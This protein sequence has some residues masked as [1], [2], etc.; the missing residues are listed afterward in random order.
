MKEN[1]IINVIDS[2]SSE[3]EFLSNFCKCK[4]FFRGI[5][6]PTLEHAYQASKCSDVRFK[7]I[8]A[9][10][11]SPY[12]AKKMGRSCFDPDWDSKKVE[13][14]YV[15]LKYKFSQD[16][17]KQKLLATEN[18]ELVEGNWWGDTYWG[19]CKGKGENMLGKLLMRVRKELRINE[20]MSKK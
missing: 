4:I 15:L 18:I 17:F 6:Y 8:I 12:Q 14:M 13:I 19:I 10:N 1:Q 16:S 20:K 3:Y 5:K 11:P 7:K 2:F 9:K